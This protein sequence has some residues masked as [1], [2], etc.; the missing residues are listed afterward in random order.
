MWNICSEIQYIGQKMK[1]SINDFP[2]KCDQIRRK[3]RFWSYLLKKSLWKT[4]F[5][6]LCYF[7][8]S[9]KNTWYCIRKYIAIK[10]L[11]EENRTHFLLADNTWTYFLLTFSFIFFFI[12]S[13]KSKIHV[14]HVV[15]QTATWFIHFT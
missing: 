6:V 10:R 1:S 9:R 2:S 5:F 15:G 3:L 12:I 14:K 4:L 13:V 8:K 7:A 11:N